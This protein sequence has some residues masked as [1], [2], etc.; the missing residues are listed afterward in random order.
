MHEKFAGWST[1]FLQY[2]KR[3]WK[4]LIIW[5]LSIV[6]FSAGFVPAFKEIA[7]GKGLLGM[8]ETL[9]NPAMISMVGP[10]PVET[11]TDYTVGAMYAHE[12]LLFCGLFAIIVS[13]L[14][15]VGHTRKE[16]ELGLTELVRSFQIGRQA[17]SLAAIMEIVLVNVVIAGLIFVMMI[18][19]SVE[20]ISIQ[21]ALLF[22]IT[23]GMAGIM[24]ASIALVMS[25]IMPTSSSATGASLSIVGLL[26]IIRAGTDVSNI[27]LSNINPLGWTY[28]TYPFTDNNWI[29]IVIAF[30]FSIIVVVIAIILEG[31]RDMGASYIPEKKGRAR[32]KKSL[33]SIHGLLYKINKS[34]II[35]WL[36]AF[37]VMGMAYGSI[38]GDMQT[39]LE[40]NEMMKQMFSNSN[41][42]IE[43]S[44][45]STIMIVLVSLVGILPIVIVNKLFSEESKLRL[46][47]IYP[48]KV[49]RSN[50]Y[51]NTIG[52]AFLSS[53]LGVLVA[54]LSLGMIGI[55][56]MEGHGELEITNFLAAGYNFLPAILFFISLAALAI[57]WAPKLGK[58][59]YAYLGYNFAINYF[60]NTLDLPEWFSKTAI[61]NWLPQMPKDNFDV[62]TFITLTIIGIIFIVLGYIGYR[63]RD[64]IG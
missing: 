44:F 24:G 37:M 51:W 31:A 6:L 33:L 7:Q 9:Q 23:I 49:T 32:A 30:L 54:T 55:N 15:V 3:D 27:D 13:M 50:V 63:K 2:L 43:A 21:G 57:G 19:F 8:F 56:A 41:V 38:Y 47:Q 28:L 58:L 10:T 18:S 42:S 40:S 17:N 22:G 46:S 4:K 64:L 45:T 25:Q 62:I 11:A 53:I 48:T 34:I 39:F 16:E 29:P 59:A 35:S 12:M 36:I 60:G 52:L 5:I 14:H 26:Y 20:T 61:L 1:L